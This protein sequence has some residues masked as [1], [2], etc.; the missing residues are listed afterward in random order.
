MKDCILKNR[1][2]TLFSTALVILLWGIFANAVNNSIKIPSPSETVLS[3]IDIVKSEHFLIEIISSLKRIF[4]SFII[5]FFSGIGL[6]VVAGF[7]KPV[8]YLLQPIVLTLRAMPTMGVI[9]LS[10]IWLNREIAPV[11]VGILVIFPIIYSSVISG[12]RNIDKQLLE[13]TQIYD[14]GKKK[15][16]IHLYIPSIRSSLVSVSAAAISLNIKVSIAAEVL[17]QPQYSIGTGFQMEKVALNTAGVLAW[18][19]VAIILAGFS[20]WLITWILNQKQI[21]TNK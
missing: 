9:L 14:F 2:Y 13:M 16:F 4:L 17:S 5:S 15:K 11:L 3:F 21:F 1:L 6:G 19:I 7:V 12:V 18:S 8:Y 20:E 10:L